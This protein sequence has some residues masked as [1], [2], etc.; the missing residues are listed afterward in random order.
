MP[1]LYVYIS[2]KAN[3]RD[4]FLTFK[5]YFMLFTRTEKFH[6]LIPKQDLRNRLIGGHVRIHN[7]DFEVTEKDHLLRIIPHAEDVNT[8]ITLPI[9]HIDVKEAGNKTN[10]VVTST[11]RRFDAG[12]PML[13]TI[14]CI[15]LFLVAMVL[16]Y[17]GEDRLISYILLGISLSIFAI[18]WVRLE[19]GYFD[20]I[21][22]ISAHIKSKLEFTSIF[23]E[24]LN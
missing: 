23:S 10:V 16:L 4:H 8:I 21:R 14:F 7:M 20:Y 1:V 2:K 13:I 18:F 9:T 19:M 17:I 12:G 22:K 3:I 6:S 15:F 24:Q 11:L 5:M